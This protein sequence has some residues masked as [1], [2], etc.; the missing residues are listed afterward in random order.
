MGTGYRRHSDGAS[1]SRWRLGFKQSSLGH[2]VRVLR[3]D[4]RE[5]LSDG[6]RF[7]DM[8]WSPSGFPSR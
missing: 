4:A 7:P 1:L 5:R 2:I 8:L 6:H 3:Y